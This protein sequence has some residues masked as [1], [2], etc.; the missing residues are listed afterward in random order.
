MG[1][2]A[3]VSFVQDCLVGVHC[4]NIITYVSFNEGWEIF[5]PH[6]ESNLG[7]AF[8]LKRLGTLTKV[9]YYLLG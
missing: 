4:E 2:P 3:L 8:A 9:I 6:S 1:Q 5:H 7:T